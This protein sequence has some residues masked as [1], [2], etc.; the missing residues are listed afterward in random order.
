DIRQALN[1]IEQQYLDTRTD[2]A[3]RLFPLDVQAA[4]KK[5]AE[6]RNSFEHQIAYLVERQAEEKRAAV[7]WDNLKGDKKENW[8][9]LKEELKAFDK[10][11]PKP[12]PQLITVSD[13][14][15]AVIETRIP[16]KT[17]SDTFQPAFLEVLGG[18]EATVA[19]PQ[20]APSSTGRR[21]ALAEWITNPENPLTARV[22]V[23]RVWQYHFGRGI[24]SS[25]N[26][27]GRLGTKPSHPELLDWLATEFIENGYHLKPLHR[28]ILLSRT[29]QQSAFHPDAEQYEQIDPEN[30]YLWRTRIRR[31]SA[32]EIRDSMLSLTGELDLGM[33]GPGHK[34]E[35]NRRSLYFRVM[36]N[37]PVPFLHTMGAPEGIK[38]TPTR[39]IATTAPQAL[40]MMNGEFT[41]QR[42]QKLAENLSEVSDP[43]AFVTQ[44]FTTTTGQLPSE[45]QLQ[46]AIAFLSTG[47]EDETASRRIDFC[48][49]LLNSNSFLYVD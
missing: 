3:T 4:W 15:G 44:L 21:T 40:L 16:G 10:L 41:Y 23:N 19:K 36:R 13:T 46:E 45:T 47:G 6:E 25:S 38:S 14:P 33:G 8:K 9:K 30:N 22:M 39:Y 11:R 42:A 43:A 28:M 48:H 34:D 12:L 5:P 1:E 27:F 2:Q 20:Q 31:L 26:D 17:N 29:Y 35:H 32:E 18:E 37:S 49:I 24:V 7:N